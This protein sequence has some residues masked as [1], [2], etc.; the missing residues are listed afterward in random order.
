M[1]EAARL[2][3]PLLLA[4]ILLLVLPCPL[5]PSIEIVIKFMPPIELILTILTDIA[6]KDCTY[7]FTASNASLRTRCVLSI[8]MGHIKG[9]IRHAISAAEKNS[10]HA[11]SDRMAA[12]RACG[13]G[14]FSPREKAG[15]ST[16][17]LVLALA[18]D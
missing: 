14:S 1:L 12:R 11:V 17:G 13:N 6:S 4:S 2:P 18:T 5:L 15:N 16:L 3:G 8:N 7:L 10:S 9:R